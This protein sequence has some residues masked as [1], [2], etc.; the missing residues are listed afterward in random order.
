MLLDFFLLKMVLD[1]LLISV[2]LSLVLFVFLEAPLF[3]HILQLTS[4]S[5][6][7]L[8]RLLFTFILGSLCLFILIVLVKVYHNWL[9]HLLGGHQWRFFLGTFHRTLHLFI[10]CL[11]SLRLRRSHTRRTGAFFL[12]EFHYL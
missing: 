8:G 5:L 10:Q 12:A 7:P 6:T 1:L 2:P 4:Y 11:L 3:S 9:A